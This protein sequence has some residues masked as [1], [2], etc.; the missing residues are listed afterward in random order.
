MFRSIGVM[1]RNSHTIKVE[2]IR[3][4]YNTLIYRRYTYAITTWRPT[5]T[6]TTRR[7][8]SVLSWEKSSTTNQT[9][10]NQSQISANF[11][12]FK[13]ECDCMLCAKCFGLFANENMSTSFKKCITNC[14][15]LTTKQGPDCF[16]DIQND[17]IFR[18]VNLRNTSLNN[19]KQPNNLARLEKYLQGF[20]LLSSSDNRGL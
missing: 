6:S 10:T 16:L 20:T 13:G 14:L 1:K 19:F 5:L 2:V 11:N 12:Q 4:L 7:L 8:E 15:H 17:L 3:I 18:C 9:N